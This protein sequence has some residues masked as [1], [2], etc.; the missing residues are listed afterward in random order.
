MVTLI[1]SIAV[2]A[3]FAAS[4]AIFAHHS[5]A[6]FV[7]TPVW[8]SGTIVK[9]RAADPHV[10]I[11]LA[12]AQ[13]NGKARKWVIEGPRMGRLER[14]LPNNG[15]MAANRILKAGDRIAVC[16]FP[17][18][19]DWDPKGMYADWPPEEGRFVHGQVLVM[20][21][22]RLQSWGPYG[23]IDNCVRKGD[24]QTTWAA[25]LNRDPLARGQWCDART[26]ILVQHDT[27]QSLRE[28]ITRGLNTP[29]P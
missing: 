13:S 8:V 26:Y 1:R 9:Y 6:M 29:C 7:A 14:I 15:D 25:F 12:E 24:T 2:A 10:M 4:G 17:L 27:P 16:G 5:Q 18:K 23:V 20:P 28:E 19:K 21:D 3:L 11:E 22:G